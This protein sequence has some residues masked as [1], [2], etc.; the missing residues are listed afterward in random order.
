[1]NIAAGKM[2]RAGAMCFYLDILSKLCLFFYILSLPND[3]INLR[4][5]TKLDRTGTK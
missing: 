5:M 1:M 4:E 2:L 3:T